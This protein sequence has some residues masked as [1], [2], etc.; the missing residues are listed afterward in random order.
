MLNEVKHLGLKWMK[1]ILHYAMLQ[2]CPADLSGGCN[3]RKRKDR[4]LFDNLLH[5]F[6][7]VAGQRIISSVAIRMPRMDAERRFVVECHAVILLGRSKGVYPRH[8]VLNRIRIA[9]K[10]MY[11]NVREHKED[12]RIISQNVIDDFGAV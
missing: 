8:E 9:G 5:P 10:V 4:P 2:F 6:E 1:E 3:R 7:L 11:L 12:V